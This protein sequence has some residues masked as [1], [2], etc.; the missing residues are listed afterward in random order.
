MMNKMECE[1]FNWLNDFEN[2]YFREF[3]KPEQIYYRIHLSNKETHATFF[4]FILLSR[5]GF[6][7]GH[8]ITLIQ[9]LKLQENYYLVLS[10][11]FERKSK[12]RDTKDIVCETKYIT[13][14]K[15]GEY[16][17]KE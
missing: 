13:I 15:D 11:G 3:L 6:N 10:V 9:Q 8:I 14:G 5:Q 17:V 7:K 1:L 16:E 2:K 12:K 4:D